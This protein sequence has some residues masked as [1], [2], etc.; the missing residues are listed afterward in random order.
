MGKIEENKKEKK[1][2]LLDSAFSLFTEQGMAKTSISDI[3][4]RSGVAKGT[5]YLYFRD[6]YDIA[7]KL[8]AHKSYRLFQHAV[9]SMNGIQTECFEDTLILLIDDLIGQL[10]AEPMLLRFIDKNLSWGIFKSAVTGYREPI[11]YLQY[12]QELLKQDKNIEWIEPELMLYTVIELVGS[13]CHSVILEKDPTDL[14][15]Y[16]PYLYAAVRSIV[17]VHQKE[18]ENGKTCQVC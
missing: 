6:K 12:F 5:F 17:R 11:N 10:N 9:K 3:T 7:N 1:Q 14:E 15:H 8:I 13:T 4:R 2:R 16:K 18:K